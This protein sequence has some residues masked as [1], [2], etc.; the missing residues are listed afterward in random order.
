ME[1]CECNLVEYIRLRKQERRPFKLLEIRNFIN[2]TLVLLETF[3][4]EECISHRDIKP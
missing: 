2:E 1:K 3:E 4:R